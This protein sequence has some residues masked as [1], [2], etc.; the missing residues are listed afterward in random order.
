MPKIKLPAFLPRF[1]RRAR[2][3]LLAVVVLVG[4]GGFAYYRMVYTPAQQTNETELQTATVRQ[5][6]LVIYASGSGT[7]TSSNEV[8]LAF[9]TG[10]RVTGIF[11][12]VGDHVET[13][14]LL[15]EVDDTDAQIAYAQAKRTLAELTSAASIAAAQEAMAQAE[16]DLGDATS[17]LGYLISPAVLRWETAVQK[18]EQT[19]TEAQAAAD[20]SPADKD[21]QEALQESQDG[22]ERAKA[23]LGGVQ[24][25]YVNNYLPNNFTRWDRETGKKYVAAPSEAEI[26]QARAA[27]A[28]AQAALEEAQYLYAALTGGEVPDHATGSSLTELEQARLDFEAVQADLYGV[29]LYAPISGTIM[30]IDMSVGDTVSTTGTV[31]TVADLSQP[32]LEVF[33]DESDWVNIAVGYPAEVIFD[34]LPDQVFTGK[35]TQVDPGLYTSGNSS[36]VRAK[37]KLDDINDS[38][39]LPLGTSASVDVI[40]GSA[41]NAILVPVEAL[42]QA[43]DQYAVFVMENGEL[44]LRIV[45]V[46][47]QDL[48]YVEVLSGLEPGAVVST[49]ITE[50]K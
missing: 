42:R 1:P 41:E 23:N 16:I 6:D 11:F 2:W 12:E 28:T 47:I 27:L 25:Y 50:T 43:G 38:L 30:S 19:V 48:L 45:E 24:T 3:V 46:G 29:R 13:G 39:D 35:V 9:G 40:A 22:L 33:L 34:I 5:G 18:A 44:K 15:A 32:T 10:G 31:I 14:D 21:A 49:G 36:V 20:A 7:L 4:A 37:V 8:D 17:H 26:L